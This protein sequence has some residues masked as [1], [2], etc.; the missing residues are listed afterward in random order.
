MFIS[1]HIGSSTKL[2]G[3]EPYSKLHYFNLITN[4][5]SSNIRKNAYFARIHAQKSDPMSRF[6]VFYNL[7]V[8]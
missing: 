4:N 5:C 3:D 8:P 1:I 6:F 2:N 7:P